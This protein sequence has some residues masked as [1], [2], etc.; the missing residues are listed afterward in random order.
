MI[1]PSKN[2]IDDWEQNFSE[3]LE[4]LRKDVECVNGEL[5]QEFAILKYSPRFGDLDLI[6]NIFLTCCALHNQRKVVAGLDVEWALVDDEDEEDLDQ[7]VASVARR[8]NMKR[9]PLLHGEAMNMGPGEHE[10]VQEEVE[11]AE[12]RASHDSVKQRMIVHFNVAL[13]KG[14][15]YWPRK[16]GHVHLYLPSR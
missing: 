13:N 7:G 6:D 9:H 14:E 1:E 8:L 15:V 16:S 11:S 12:E 4:S 2:P 10:I 3:M 5:K